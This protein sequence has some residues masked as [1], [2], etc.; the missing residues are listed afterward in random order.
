MH[1][2]C[3]IHDAFIDRPN[4]VVCGSDLLWLFAV[5]VFS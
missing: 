4:V 3:F 1:D 5:Y 2:C